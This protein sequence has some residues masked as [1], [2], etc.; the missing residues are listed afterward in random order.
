MEFSIFHPGNFP[1]SS[2][3][4]NDRVRTLMSQRPVSLLAEEV[5]E[6][7]EVEVHMVVQIV[8]D[9]VLQITLTPTMD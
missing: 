1:S 6:V 8:M 4:E 5:E 7:V 2:R 3:W 9:L